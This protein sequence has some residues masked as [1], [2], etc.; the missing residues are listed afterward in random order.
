MERFKSVLEKGTFETWLDG[1]HFFKA[2]YVFYAFGNEDEGEEIYYIQANNDSK[3]MVTFTVPRNLKGDGTHDVDFPGSRFWYVDS[4]DF[5]SKVASGN[6]TLKF[7][8]G[9]QKISGGIAFTLENG[10]KL[11]GNFEINN[12]AIVYPEP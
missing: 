4:D 5:Q 7:G 8:N 6:V 9:R 10:K 1:Q 12:P 11:T 3:K 2:V